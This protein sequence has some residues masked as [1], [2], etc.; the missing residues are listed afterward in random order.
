MQVNHFMQAT[1]NLSTIQGV[2]RLAYKHF[3]LLL[4]SLMQIFKEHPEKSLSSQ[5]FKLNG[6]K[7]TKKVTRKVLKIF[8]LLDILWILI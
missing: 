1:K 2:R 3:C 5:E 4:D 8:L 7:F 6:V